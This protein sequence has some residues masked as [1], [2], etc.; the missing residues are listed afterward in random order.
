[1]QLAIA[2]VL[3]GG[4]AWSSAA[5][6]TE[7]PLF[8]KVGELRTA[9]GSSDLGPVVAISG[10]TAVATRDSENA[11]YVFEREPGG[12][13][14]VQTARLVP[15]DGGAG[16]GRSLATTGDIIVVGAPTSPLGETDATTGAAYVFRRA[17]GG[18]Y[19]AARLSGDVNPQTFGASVAVSGTTVVV[20]APVPPVPVP[21]AHGPGLVYVFEPDDGGTDGWAE[22]ARLAGAPAPVGNQVDFFGSSVDIDGDTLVVGALAP[23]VPGPPLSRSQPVAHVLSR[24]QG[25]PHAWSLVRR[26]AVGANLPLDF[27]GTPAVGI[28]GDTIVA[29]IGSALANAV[30]LF[31]RD[32]GGP[33]AWGQVAR[34]ELGS[35]IPLY[36][37]VSGNLAVVS[38]GRGVFQIPSTVRVYARHQGASDQWGEVANWEFDP[39]SPPAGQGLALS[40]DT[41][42]SGSAVGQGQTSMEVYVGDTDRDGIRDG[43][44]ACPRDPFNNVTGACQRATAAYL[45]LDDLIALDDVA[46]ESRGNEFHITATFTNTS[47]T[48]IGNPFF[49]VTALTGGNVLVNAD[50]GPGGVGAT[51]SP[52]VGDGIL[53]P[54]ESTTVAFVIGLA[55][56]EAFQFHVSIRGEAG[57]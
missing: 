10:D 36:A 57:R 24:V 6:S 34:L 5:Q 3:F 9:D 25:D 29:R 54:G 17:G 30:R 42:L 16:F 22:T 11:V 1:V 28:S 41:I 12:D 49:E 43:A 48:A 18:W 21:P 13:A 33:D 40:G 27:A 39:S 4:G 55:T 50:A 32:R 51:L 38:G 31:Q 7:S 46:T 20:G 53:S 52:D 19:E 23:I 45:L 56:R 14:F 44:D 35:D 15:S 47:E 2:G 8:V 26:I 37:R